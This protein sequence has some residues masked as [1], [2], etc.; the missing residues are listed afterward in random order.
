MSENQLFLLNLNNERKRLESIFEVRVEE[1]ERNFKLDVAK[2][3]EDVNRTFKNHIN[4]T[5]I[6]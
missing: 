4:L 6:L 1:T 3:E 2:F 5:K